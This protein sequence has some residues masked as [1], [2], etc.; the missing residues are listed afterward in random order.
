MS[1]L[2][3]IPES[4]LVVIHTP[5]L[6]VL[7]IR[8]TDAGTWQSVTGS[9]DAPD[10]PFVQTAIREVAEETGIDCGPGSPLHTGL[11]DWHLENI[12]D[13]YPA[14]LAPLPAGRHAQH[15]ACVWPADTRG[16][17]HTPVRCGTHRIPVAALAGEAADTCFSPSNAEAILMLPRFL[18]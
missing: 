4:V 18:R 17:G 10:E 14:W 16:H 13:I 5:A 3:K 8:R 2:H 6:D 9:R 7:L 15:R 1:R 11:T 12:Y